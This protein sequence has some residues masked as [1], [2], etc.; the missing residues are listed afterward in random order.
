MNQAIFKS[1][2]DK[3]IIQWITV[4][5]AILSLLLGIIQIIDQ[6]YSAFLVN[7]LIA[8]YCLLIF[9]LYKKN[10]HSAAFWLLFLSLP[11]VFTINSYIFGNLNNQ[12]YLISGAVLAT[13]LS[14]RKKYWSDIVWVLSIIFFIGNLIL[15]YVRGEFNLNDFEIV[16]FFANGFLAVATVYM[17]SNIFKN[18]QEKQTQQL[19][20]SNKSKEKLI[21]MLSHDFRSPINSIK[22]I[23]ELFKLGEIDEVEFQAYINKLS[24]Q[25]ETTSSLMDNTLYWIKSQMESTKPNIEDILVSEIINPIVK[26][27]NSQIQA[28]NITLISDLEPSLKI[29]SDYNILTIIIRNL[30]SNAIKFTKPNTGLITIKTGVNANNNSIITITDNGIGMSK[31]QLKQLFKSNHSKHGTSGEKGFGLGLSLVK[32][33]TELLQ[34]SIDTSSK[35]NHGTT[36]R[37]QFNG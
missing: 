15:L 32:S 6:K 5:G 36:I 8:G 16:P 14:R 13:F 35:V 18:Q 12:L 20:E 30:L 26:S 21:A 7:I 17:S 1:A 25:I 4:S 19:E 33:Y 2:L 37:L 10:Y 31:D 11:I 22:G 34:I 24:E 9:I 3:K 28:K 27:L 29:K 23:L